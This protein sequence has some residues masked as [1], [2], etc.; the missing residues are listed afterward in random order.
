MFEVLYQSNQILVI[1]THAG[2]FD[3]WSDDIYG[4]FNMGMHVGDNSERVLINRANL[5]TALNEL[6]HHQITQIHWLGQIH[7]DEVICA[8]DVCIAPKNG[9]ALLT[10]KKGVALSIMTADCVP[11]ALF[12]DM[13]E[14][15]A[16]IHAGW[17]GL[18]KGI[19]KNTANQ[20]HHKNIKAV[21]G[22]CIS[23]ANYEIDKM[24]ANNIVNGVIEKNLVNL[25]FDELYQTIIIDKDNDKC[26]I[27]IVKLTQLQL[28]HL[29]ITVMNDKVPCSYATPNLYSYRQQ[30]HA[31]KHATGRMALVVARY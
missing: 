14:Q 7:G 28:A 4:Q 23:Q 9:D 24:L 25:T 8:D 17:Q 5:L 30:T 6:T 27:D 16:C 11:I 1:Q 3:K 31:K 13:G 10:D 15:I 19:I 21:I 12:D 29:N 18:V 22:A 26:S 2:E 20:F